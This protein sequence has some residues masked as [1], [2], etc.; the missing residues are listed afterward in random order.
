[1]TLL[2]A[3]IRKN[4]NTEELVIATDSQLRFGAAWD[5]C[6]K[7]LMLPRSDANLCF[8]GDTMYAYP[9]M[10]QIRNAIEMNEKV[11][12]RAMDITDLRSRILEI[13]EDMRKSIYDVPIGLDE[14]DATDFRF[15]LAGYSWKFNEFKIWILQYQTDINRFS[16]RT[17]SSHSKQTAG[18][19]YFFFEGDN[20]NT[21]RKKLY[22]ILR[23]RK[24][25]TVGGLDMEPFEVLRDMIRDPVF[26]SIGGPPQI[27]K[28]Y[29]HLNTLPYNVFWPTKGSAQITFLG[30][31]LLPYET[32]RF[33]LL[34]PDTFAVYNWQGETIVP[35]VDDNAA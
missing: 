3:W 1:M 4:K 18:T 20:V 12:S 2:A 10:L 32:N 26:S 17:V 23:T 16:F 28:I 21:A 31:P 7:I 33:L 27:V 9:I 6:P 14:Y 13:I 29:K 19:K 34:D 22:E 11:R 35:T 8:A 24:K 30:R 15:I 5:C 25:M